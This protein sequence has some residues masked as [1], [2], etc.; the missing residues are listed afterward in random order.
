MQTLALWV[1]GETG[2][3][4][5]GTLKRPRARSLGSAG[6]DSLRKCQESPLCCARDDAFRVEWS[7]CVLI[8]RHLCDRGV[9]RDELR[10]TGFQ[11]RAEQ[12]AG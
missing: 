11:M 9:A 2:G 6:L 8:R 7:Y 3:S 1:L 10:H 12:C 5:T 4:I